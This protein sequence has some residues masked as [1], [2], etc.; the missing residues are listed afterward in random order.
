MIFARIE[1][2]RNFRFL[3]NIPS[4]KFAEVPSKGRESPGWPSELL[5]NQIFPAINRA[6]ANS[7]CFHMSEALADQTFR[8]G[9]PRWTLFIGDKGT[10]DYVRRDV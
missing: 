4:N 3:K 1:R 6:Q 10:S 2:F 5:A 8:R 9:Y 7:I